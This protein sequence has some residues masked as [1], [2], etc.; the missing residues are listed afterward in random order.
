MP[1]AQGTVV[2]TVS[3]II[4]HYIPLVL[5]LLSTCMGFNIWF[6]V[7]QATNYVERQLI[8]WYCLFS[9]G[10]P[11]VT[12]VTAI[13]LL[14]NEPQWSAYPRQYYCSLRESNIT[15]VTFGVFMLL[16]ALL[17]IGF[18]LHTVVYL[19]R[20][21]FH[22]RSTVNSGSSMFQR[23]L[24][25]E[26]SHCIRL[27]VFSFSFGLIVLMAVLERIIDNEDYPEPDYN[28][29]KSLSVTSDF[30]G[31][32]IAFVFFFIFGTTK[33]SLRTLCLLLHPWRMCQKQKFEVDP[34]RQPHHLVD[35]EFSL[36]TSPVSSLSDNGLT[37]ES[38]I[39]DNN[40]RST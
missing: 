17:G 20:H 23:S 28:T 31:S 29:T 10:I 37:F 16:A 36:R 11:L 3:A 25:I 7:V 34:R 2:C 35:E 9:F 19:I 33:D 5:A 4:E 32:L 26:L 39:L 8:R 6:L 13:I 1:E 21:Y 12:T 30:S 40:D 24:V 15:L 27:I 14:R 22:L 38:M 18:T